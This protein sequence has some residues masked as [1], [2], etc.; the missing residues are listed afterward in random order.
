MAATVRNIRL[1]TATLAV[2]DVLFA[3]ARSGE[4]VWGFKIC[5]H[6]GLG[7]GT[8]YPILDRLE[9]AR[10]ISGYWEAGQPTDRPRRRLYE[11]TAHGRAELAAGLATRPP[12]RVTWR[13]LA[14]RG[15]TA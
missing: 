1:T 12:A 9:T 11:M 2:L 15:S 8:V 13:R 4:S 10:W 6:A 5:D 14:Q 7:P 3:C